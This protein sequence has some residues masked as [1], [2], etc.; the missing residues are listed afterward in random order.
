[1]LDLTGDLALL[2][3]PLKGHVIAYRAGHDLHAALAQMI[4][5]RS[6]SWYLAGWDEVPVPW[7]ARGHSE[8]ELLPP[9]LFL[10]YPPKSRCAGAPREREGLSHV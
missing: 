9:S 8:L 1:M 10:A 5:H 2:G 4:H 7:S 3:R 6:D